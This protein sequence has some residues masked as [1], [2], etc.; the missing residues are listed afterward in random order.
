MTTPDVP[1]TIPA[2][3]A[4]LPKYRREQFD[5]EI[6]SATSRN[7]HAMLIKWM[8]E[9]R[10][11]ADVER[12]VAELTADEQR[13]VDAMPRWEFTL[14]LDRTLT[15]WDTEP[16]AR[17]GEDLGDYA[18]GS[19]GVT[20]GGTGPSESHCVTHGVSLLD[21]ASRAA[22]A[23]HRH[24]GARAVRIEVDEEHRG[25]LAGLARVE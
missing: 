4:A 16:F 9:A 6:N 22:Q 5:I 13:A 8:L 19:I 20:W 3:R 15:E 2:V 17:L 12:A 21:A 25:D 14:V 7:I 10:P 18:N 24:T 1:D 23:I 11:D